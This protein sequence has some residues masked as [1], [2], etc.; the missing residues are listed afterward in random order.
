VYDPTKISYSELLDVFWNS[1][2]PYSK[3]Y[4][5]QYKSIIFYHNEEQY[6][7]AIESRNS[8]EASTGRKIVTEIRP[9]STFFQAEDYHQKYY[10]AVLGNLVKEIRAIYPDI[11][12]YVSSTAVARINGYA[13]GYGSEETLEK[14]L[15]SLGLSPEGMEELR[16]I[17][18][19]GL[20]SACPV[21]S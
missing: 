2:N 16:E 8:L 6:Q 14:E 19:K 17:A 1:H 15:S 12:D 10:M 4:S 18:G 21:T 3:A 11:N 7:Q 5:T 9:A 20:V 13:G